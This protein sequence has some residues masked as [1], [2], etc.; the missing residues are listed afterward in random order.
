MLCQALYPWPRAGAAWE[1]GAEQTCWSIR[2]YSGLLFPYPYPQATS[3]AGP[4]GGMEYPMFVMVHYGSADPASIFETLD[5]EQGHAWFPMLVGSNER[6]YAWQ[7]EGVNTYANA[8]SLERRYPGR[9]PAPA[10]REEWATVAGTPLDAPLM[11]RPD[12]LDP[13]T[14]GALGYRK[15]GAV[16]L[17]L[18]NH[19][20]GA[21]AFDRA[22]REY[23]RRW[24]FRHPT[25]ADFFRTVENVTGA[26]LSWFWRSFFYT[27]DV[28]DLALESVRTDAEGAVL[29]VRRRTAVPFPIAARVRLAD[30]SVREVRAPVDVWARAGVGDRVEVR[31]PGPGT[32]VGAR[33]WPA[34][35]VPDV[36]AA[37][38]AWGEAPPAPP[39][40]AE[41]GGGLAGAVGGA[42]GAAS[43]RGGGG[44]R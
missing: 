28:L 1:G 21:E 31:V 5:H 3:M 7:D 4:V 10:Y 30:G 8:F 27:T 25:P 40:G 26:D 17:A 9:S 12:H 13:R 39:P 42:A 14:L 32:V 22:L 2:T 38:D 16:L 33:L 34:P 29:V 6:R 35:G 41:T 19:V 18:R 20:V 37:N 15:P 43:Q 24:A 23:V 36:D 11:T 44:V